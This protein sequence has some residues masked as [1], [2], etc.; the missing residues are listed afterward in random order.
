SWMT[1]ADELSNADVTDLHKHILAIDPNHMV[2]LTKEWAERNR[3][4]H[5]QIQQFVFDCRWSR[6]TQHVCRDLTELLHIAPDADTAANYQKVLLNIRDEFFDVQ[7]GDDPEQ[8]CPNEKARKLSKEEL[9]RGRSELRSDLSL[10]ISDQT[11]ERRNQR[12]NTD[13]GRIRSLL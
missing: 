13:E 2:W 10:L 5:N 11:Q 12:G 9:A 4:F 6:L 3:I 7:S 8:W 1:F